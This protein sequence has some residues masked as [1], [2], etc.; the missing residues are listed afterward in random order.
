MSVPQDSHALRHKWHRSTF[1]NF[2]SENISP[3]PTHPMTSRRRCICQPPS[4]RQCVWVSVGKLDVSSNTSS[5]MAATL[6]FVSSKRRSQQKTSLTA[7]VIENVSMNRRLSLGGVN[8]LT[9]ALWAPQ[10]Y[11][12]PTWNNRTKVAFPFPHDSNVVKSETDTQSFWD[13]TQFKVL[14]LSWGEH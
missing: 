9:S 10:K 1:T 12:R 14:S 8:V 2:V 13:P 4:S 6:L 5:A 3:P 7:N 11:R